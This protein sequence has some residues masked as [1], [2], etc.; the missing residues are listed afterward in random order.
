MSAEALKITKAFVLHSG[1]VDSSTCLA[2]AIRNHSRENVV[3]ISV[4]YGQRHV[5]EIEQA[6]RICEVFEV[7]HSTLEITDMPSS[8]L[9]DQKQEIPNAD[10]SELEGVSPTYVP[11]RNGQLL[12]KIAAYATAHSEP[13]NLGVIY[14]GAH[15]ED[16]LNWAYPDCTPEFIGAMANAIHIGTYFQIRLSTPLMWLMKWEIIREGNLRG[17]PWILTWSC[18]VGEEK[19]C[20]VCPTCRSRKE[21]FHKA[22]VLDPTPYDA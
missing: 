4:D 9:T 5:K 11:F 21:A 2:M 10:Y 20:G 6:K 1:G 8:M 17:V 13:D 16:A 14:F 3:A 15:S 19:H 7:P 18:Y 22:A 12:S